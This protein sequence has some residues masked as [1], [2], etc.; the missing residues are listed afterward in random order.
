M[1]LIQEL[2]KWYLSQCDGTWE[3]SFGVK[4]DTLD[5]P[6]WSLKVDIRGTNLVAR[7]FEKLERLGHPENWVQCQVTEE[8]F[9]GHGG[10][11]MLE[12]ILS[13]FLKWANE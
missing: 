13:V 2:Q 12:E 5:N 10:P 1:S 7:P 4:I 9:E 3:H 11:F 6:G 8:R